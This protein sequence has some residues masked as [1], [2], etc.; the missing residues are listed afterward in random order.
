MNLVFKGLSNAR[1]EKVAFVA[2]S[3]AAVD[4]RGGGE[5]GIGPP[6][7]R[8][9]LNAEVDGEWRCPVGVGLLIRP[10]WRT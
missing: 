3:I 5:G 9:V 7:R 8:E 10:Q 6:T 1:V 2:F 4:I